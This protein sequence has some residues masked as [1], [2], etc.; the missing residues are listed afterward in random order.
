M[1]FP[2]TY[3]L[4][5]LAPSETFIQRELDQLRRRNWPVSLWLL[6]GESGALKFS[7]AACPR[8]LRWRFFKA[9]CARVLEELLRSPLAA[10]RMLKR[11]PQAAHLVKKAADSDSR[12]IHAH[13]AGITA[14]LASIAARTLGLPWTCG[15]HAHDIFTCRPAP[16]RRRLRT[17]AGIVACSR[18]AA[19]TVIAAG[20]RPEKVAVVH[21]GLPLN[22]FPFDRIQPDELLFTASR[23]EPKKGLDTLVRACALLARRGLRFTCVIAG[24]G[25]SERALKRLCKQLGLE[26]TVYFIGWQS[27]EETRSRLMDASALVLPSRRTRDG[28]RDGIAN[29]LVEAMAIGTPVVTTTAGAAAELITHNVNGLLVPPDDPDALADALAAALTTK[30]LLVRLSKAARLTVEEHFDGSKNILLLEAFLTQ[31][32]EPAAPARSPKPPSHA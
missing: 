30:E 31:A 24:T 14:D 9:A 22:D 20:L 32:A 15:V 23:L 8:R 19:D 4:D 6:N 27:Q 21:H 16:L 12:L 2:A 28:D 18:L 29:I 7:L 11:L 13:F 3:L 17:A 25:P 5:R 1:P 10:G 26:Q